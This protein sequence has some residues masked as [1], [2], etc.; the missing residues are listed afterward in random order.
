MSN[1]YVLAMYDV[2]G[3]QSY[4]FR[5]NHMRE[6]IGAS[7]IIRDVFTSYLY[8]AAKEYR[9]SRLDGQP[10]T[11]Q[12]AILNL[13]KTGNDEP[14][15]E[16]F[17]REDFISRMNNDLYVGEM[18][19]DGG[20]NFFVLYKDKETA[21]QINKLFSKKVIEETDTLKVLSTY[22]ENVNFDDYKADQKR[23][24]SK[25]EVLS[26]KNNFELPSLVLPIVQVDNNTS[27]P[28]TDRSEYYKG[29]SDDNKVTYESFA[30]YEKY[31][32]ILKNDVL[33]GFNNF[34]EGEKF[35]DKLVEE[36]GNESLLAIVYIDGNN[37]GAAVQECLKDKRSYE[38]C[39][40]ELRRFSKEIQSSFV[41]EGIK[42]INEE[43]KK[44]YATRKY[45][46]ERRIVVFA[47]DEIN[48]IVNARDA[49]DAVKAYF[50]SL[51]QVNQN[52]SACAGISIFHSHAPYSDAYRIAE[53]CCESGKKRM[54]E[55]K[56]SRAFY[57][58]YQYNQGAIGLELESI[59][60]KDDRY[61]D[62]QE[63]GLISKPWLYEGDDV[64]TVFTTENVEE[65]AKQLN[66]IGRS[67]V[68]TLVNAAKKSLNDF[69]ME[70]QRIYAHS[71]QTI[72]FSLNNT[73]KI[74]DQ[75]KLI[76]DVGLVYDLWFRKD[77]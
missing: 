7:G 73:L 17:S 4:I 28:L 59:R 22:I 55:E 27:M 42:A 69:D 26:S 47:G 60:R 63:K 62:D 41:E 75:R 30:K 64:K 39:I 72:D 34:S 19:Y 32:E 57:V 44:K 25:H 43:L 71:E 13:Q 52:Y 56:I 33:A 40:K 68:K 10:D 36:K 37:M 66:K 54:K 65:M 67:N 18:I 46:K 70:V 16:T 58:D 29:N 3:K 76:Y 14:K 51:K 74:N 9:D 8:D 49:Y 77:N 15:V 50:A 24:Y 5:N 23:L 2:R 53:E 35:L 31:G 6:I 61:F 12:T 45:G 20:G 11:G 1:N 48:F 21:C 38:D